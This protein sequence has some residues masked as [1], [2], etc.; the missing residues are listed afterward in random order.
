MPIL[1]PGGIMQIA[2]VVEDLDKAVDHWAKVLGVGPF[3]IRRH[4]QY[5]TLTFR[6]GPCEAD[7]SLAFAFSGDTQI[8]LVQQHNAAP[9]L[10]SEFIARHGYGQQHLGVISDDLAADVEKFT[11]RGFPVVQHH[12][13]PNGIETM[14]F[15]TDLHAGGVIELIGSTPALTEGFA[16]MKEAARTWDGVDPRRE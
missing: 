10:Y 6:G 15:E 14:L 16:A 2:Y 12:V 8:E 9:S 1:P 11:A 7:L 5:P 13:N 3:F 4:V